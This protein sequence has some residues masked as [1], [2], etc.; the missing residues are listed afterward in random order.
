MNNENVFITKVVFTT[1]FEL[2]VENV[3]ARFHDSHEDSCCESH[4]LDWENL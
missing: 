3:E 4:Y 1:P 2:T